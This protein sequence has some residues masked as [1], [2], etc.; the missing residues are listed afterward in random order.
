MNINSICIDNYNKQKA[1]LKTLANIYW[2]KCA[3]IITEQKNGELTKLQPSVHTQ[4]WACVGHTN[5]FNG[6]TTP[7]TGVGDR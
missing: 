1:C 6:E 7:A 3:E 5:Y 4:M 2:A